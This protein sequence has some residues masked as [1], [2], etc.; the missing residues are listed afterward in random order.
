MPSQ[1][2][3]F[4]KDR[5]DT[6][7]FEACQYPATAETAIAWMRRAAAWAEKNNQTWLVD[8]LH[9]TAMQF[10]MKSMQQALKAA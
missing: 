1:T 10:L 4:I 6:L 9:C 5:T 7:L 8:Y 2:A 3:Y